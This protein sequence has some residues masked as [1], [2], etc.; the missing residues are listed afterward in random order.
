[1]CCEDARIFNR[2]R[3]K[4][5]RVG[6]LTAAAKAATQNEAVIAALKRCATKIE[7]KMKFFRNLLKAIEEAREG[8]GA[9]RE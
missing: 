9:L 5:F 2:L 4:G 7:P 1:M 3:K 8:R 6:N